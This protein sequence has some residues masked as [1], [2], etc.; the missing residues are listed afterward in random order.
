M[1]YLLSLWFDF[2]SN[3]TVS[4]YSCDEFQQTGTGFTFL[5]HL[6]Y[7]HVKFFQ[8]SYAQKIIINNF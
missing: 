4:Y 2:S 5:P 6:L 3:F 8:K 1:T 7:C